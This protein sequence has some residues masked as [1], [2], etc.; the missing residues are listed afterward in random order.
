[1]TR[2][3]RNYS[4]FSRR[5]I[6][7]TSAGG[8]AHFG[9]ARCANFPPFPNK[10]ANPVCAGAFSRE[11]EAIPAFLAESKIDHVEVPQSEDC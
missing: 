10:I 1:M 6:M 5:Q 4:T 9:G 11:R 8:I 3:D 7:I 2:L